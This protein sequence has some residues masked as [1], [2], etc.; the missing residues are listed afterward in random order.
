MLGRWSWW[1]PTG[2]FGEHP[3]Q[4]ATQ[5]QIDP[6][7]R[8]QPDPDRLETVSG[9]QRRPPIVTSLKTATEASI[10]DQSLGR[11]RGG[12]PRP[13]RGTPTEIGQAASEL[14]LLMMEPQVQ[15]I[16][17]RLSSLTVTT[18]LRLSSAV[19]AKEL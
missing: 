7:V 15:Q 10:S 19:S 9:L 17:A 16:M 12:V 18:W 3:V 11:P 2:K 1:T 8:H 6:Q 13:G 14:C 5:L 4:V